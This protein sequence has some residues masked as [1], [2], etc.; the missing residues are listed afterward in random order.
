MS[1]ADVTPRS[2]TQPGAQHC[3]AVRVE[4]PGRHRLIEHEVP[5]PG[6]GEVLV[7]VAA[8]GVCGSD[9]ELFE[10]RRPAPYVRYPI[11]PGHEWAGRIAAVGQGAEALPIGASVVAEGFRSCLTCARCRAGEPTLCTADYAETGFT[12]PGAFSRFL[13]VPSRLVH[14]LPAELPTGA[15]LGDC[16]LL[17]PAACVA[18]GLLAAQPRPGG[19]FTVLG[20]GTLSLLAVQMLAAYRPES[21]TVV[22]RGDQHFALAESFGATRCLRSGDAAGLA[23]VAGRADLVFEATGAAAMVPLSFELARRGAT[24]LLEGIAGAGTVE[25]DPDVFALKQLTVRGIFGAGPAAWSHAIDQLRIGVLD[26]PS[27]VSHRIPL[28]D[29]ARGMELLGNRPPELKKVLFVPA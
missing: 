29:Y 19:R 12:H 21:L 8:A 26:L 17:E 13:T 18:A 23:A 28:A 16:A 14:L 2:A 20:T 27:L 7:E 4:A 5:A 3:A 22:G 9:V 25:L 11:V 6:P 24:V 1:D 10:G 15:E